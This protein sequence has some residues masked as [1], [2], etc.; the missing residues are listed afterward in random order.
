MKSARRERDR[1]ATNDQDISCED[2]KTATPSRCRKP[3]LSATLAEVAG[4][5][6]AKA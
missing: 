2:Y 6:A 4:G 5:Q 1:N 3:G